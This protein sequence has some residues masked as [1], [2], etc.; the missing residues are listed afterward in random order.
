MAHY[1]LSLIK[2]CSN[3]E[4]DL[5]TTTTTTTVSM[6]QHIASTEKFVLFSTVCISLHNQLQ[7]QQQ[8]QQQQQLLLLPPPPPPPLLL[9]LLQPKLQQ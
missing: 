3:R 9:L 7:L 6:R 4:I 2:F 5:K 1:H 8:Q